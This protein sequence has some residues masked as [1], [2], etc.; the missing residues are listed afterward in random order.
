MFGAPSQPRVI[1]L[2][3]RTSSDEPADPKTIRVEFDRA[4]AKVVRVLTPADPQM[5]LIVL[6]TV[7]DLAAIDPA[8]EAL[9]SEIGQLPTS[10]YAGLLRAQDGMS[11]LVDPGPGREP[12]VNGIRD[13]AIS[14]R[15]G[16]LEALEPVAKLADSISKKAQ[17]R[18]AVLHVSDSDVREYREDFTNPVINSSDPHDL[19]RRFPETLIQEKMTKF[20]GRFLSFET[21]VHLVHLTYRSDRL[22][23][24]YR[25]GLQRLAE[26]TNG[27]AV[28]C[29]SRAEIGDAI[30]AAFR[31]IRSE[32][33]LI[34]ALPD[35][36]PDTVQIK[37]SSNGAALA[38]RARLR[39]KE[40]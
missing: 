34:V 7:G 29:R 11:V 12:V 10:T 31:I 20:E 23:E 39:V 32:Y 33:G 9:I 19:S 24:A 16:L 4:E 25:N 6:D 37:A 2:A 5:L 35:R 18:V 3:V 27:S 13:L 22:N 21:P 8:K 1:R 38:H 26:I 14:G 30:A 28:F 15:P 36:V 40:K 17:V